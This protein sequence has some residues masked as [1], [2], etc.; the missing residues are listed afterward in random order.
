MNAALARALTLA[1]ALISFDTESSKSNR[2]L[3]DYVVDYLRRHGVEPLLAPNARGD[4]VALMAT[5][6]PMREGGIVL[7][8]HTDVVPVEGQD[9]SRDPFAAWRANGRLYGRGA[10]DMK[11]FDAV[12]LAMVPEFL[13]ADLKRPIHILLSYDEEVS[14]EGSLDIIA[15]FGRFPHR[16]AVL[17][18]PS[19][20]DET[21]YLAQPGSGF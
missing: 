17:G 6:G 10:T 1:E 4:K 20:P 5:I 18:R 12:C 11:G 14:C 16:N 8:G 7:S 19:T 9:W 15:R 13:A 2:A 3:V 21:S